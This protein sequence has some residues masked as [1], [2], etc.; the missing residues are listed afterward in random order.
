MDK[1]SFLSETLVD[2]SGRTRKFVLDDKLYK[3]FKSIVGYRY[4][5]L[6]KTFGNIKD[7][8]MKIEEKFNN[9]CDIL[10]PEFDKSVKVMSNTLDP[11]K[12]I[13]KDQL[14]L[15]PTLPISKNMQIIGRMATIEKATKYNST[16]F[17]ALNLPSDQDFEWTRDI[18]D[19]YIMCAYMDSLKNQN[20]DN[21]FARNFS[22][23]LVVDKNIPYKKVI[24]KAQINTN[25]SIEQKEKSDVNCDKECI[26]PPS[27]HYTNDIP[28]K[29]KTAPKEDQR[30]CYSQIPSVTFTEII[31]LTS[32]FNMDCYYLSGNELY[33]LY[34]FAIKNG[35]TNKME[36]AYLRFNSN[37][38]DKKIQLSLVK[39]LSETKYA[40]SKYLKYKNKYLAL[41]KKMHEENETK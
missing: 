40:K 27:I 17:K 18:N 30:T 19:A 39:I 35:K 2:K 11:L 16:R 13:N 7:T 12:N 41:K 28:A 24:D 25:L 22:L 8:N 36:P 29:C 14:K 23:V 37:S 38:R 9:I 6:E 32:Y 34:F 20:I 4:K 26:F 5:T 21:E 1:V 33:D 10:N 31:L 15:P 3:Q